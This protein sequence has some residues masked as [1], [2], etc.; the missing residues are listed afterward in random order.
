V[1]RTVFS[2]LPPPDNPLIQRRKTASG[3]GDP[4]PRPPSPYPLPLGG[5]EG[6]VR[7]A[8]R[9]T[10]SNAN[11]HPIR[12]PRRAIPM[13]VQLAKAFLSTPAGERI[14]VSE[15]DAKSLI[16]QQLAVP[17]MDELITPGVSNA[18]ESEYGHG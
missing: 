16:A 14:D 9:R 6:R 13:F 4:K 12:G 1:W 17:V 5:G 3:D 11:P 15:E 2:V 8:G 7:G 18:L 10:G